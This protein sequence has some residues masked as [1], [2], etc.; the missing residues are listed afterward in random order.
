MKVSK[1]WIEDLRIESRVTLQVPEFSIGD[2]LELVEVPDEW[3][4]R[5]KLD[6]GDRIAVGKEKAFLYVSPLGY[7]ANKS[8]LADAY[9]EGLNRRGWRQDAYI[10]SAAEFHEWAEGWFQDVKEATLWR[11][12]RESTSVKK[13]RMLMEAVELWFDDV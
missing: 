10:S 11:A 2:D 5:L 7:E 9:L 6:R 1:T 13:A 3:F 4:W 12:R 8:A